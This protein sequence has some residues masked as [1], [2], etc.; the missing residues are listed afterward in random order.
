[1]G[2]GNSGKLILKESEK[3]STQSEQ[4]MGTAVY[5]NLVFIINLRDR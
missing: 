3:I 1:M 4:R 2:T 5:E